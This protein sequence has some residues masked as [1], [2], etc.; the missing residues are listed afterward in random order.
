MLNLI[1]SKLEDNKILL[2]I[3]D[4]M[5]LAIPT[6]MVGSLALLLKSLPIEQYQYF[7]KNVCKG[8]IMQTGLLH[9]L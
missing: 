7:I 8:V 3:K 1:F 4:G 2:A 5:I 6:I 9:L